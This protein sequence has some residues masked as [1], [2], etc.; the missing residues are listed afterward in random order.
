MSPPKQRSKSHSS[1]SKHDLIKSNNRS[2]FVESS[3]DFIQASPA[4]NKFSDSKQMAKRV[5]GH[6]SMALRFTEKL[7]LIQELDCENENT[8]LDRKFGNKQILPSQR[9]NQTLKFKHASNQLLSNIL[10]KKKVNYNSRFLRDDSKARNLNKSKSIEQSDGRTHSNESTRI[11]WNNSTKLDSQAFS[12]RKL[13]SSLQ[14]TKQI[15]AESSESNALKRSRSRER[16]CAWCQEQILIHQKSRIQDCG[17][18][19]HLKC[20]SDF[21]SKNVSIDYGKENLDQSTAQS[22]YKSGA[23]MN[24]TSFVLN[25][26]MKKVD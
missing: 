8:I 12:M 6:T 1:C 5:R 20:C 23:K 19:V 22:I 24:S 2:H 16:V 26:S 13:R 25:S 21:I 3:D 11:V 9:P 15:L 18:R 17:H 14:E 10:G 7:D 4:S